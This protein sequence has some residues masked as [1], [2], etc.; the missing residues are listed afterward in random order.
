M[1]R[2]SA[3][4]PSEKDRLK[5]GHRTG[6]PTFSR[7]VEL[8]AFYDEIRAFDAEFH[9]F[10]GGLVIQGRI[11]APYGPRVSVGEPVERTK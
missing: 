10:I 7:R 11:H 9:E 8:V 3:G 6:D 2:L 1:Y 4:I 5:A